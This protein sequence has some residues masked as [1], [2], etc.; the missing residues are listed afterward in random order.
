MSEWKKAAAKLVNITPA[1]KEL[2]VKLYTAYNRKKY[3]KYWKT[4]ELDP[5]MVVF[6]SFLG[7]QYACSPKAMY[8]AMVREE[9]YR[10]Y[11]KIWMFEYPA[12]HQDVIKDENTILVKYRSKEFYEYYARAKYWITNYHLPSGVIKRPGQVYVQTWHGT[13]LK[14]IGCDVPCRSSVEEG[15]G[16]GIEM[17]GSRS[18]E[19]NRSSSLEAAK[20]RAYKEYETEGALIDFV[21]SP[22]PFYTEKFKSAFR[23]GSQAK[24]LEMGYPR[25]DAL[26]T[27]GNEKQEEMKKALGIPRDRKVILYAPTWRDNQHT[28]GTGY[29]YRLGI[30]F[31]KLQ[32]NLEGE[33]MILFRAHYLISSSFDFGK[34]QG[35]IRN[36][37]DYDDI[38]DLYM[39]ADM[40]ITDYSSVF[41]DYACLKRP[42]L[43][44]MYDYAEY[45]NQ[46][47]DFYFDISELPGPVIKEQRD[48]S[49]DIR[50]LFECFEYDEKYE[51]FNEKFN[52]INVPCSRQI[53]REIFG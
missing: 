27:V 45:K 41:F 44:Y 6:E 31:D 37:S 38:N 39:A 49:E 51:R 36:V 29:T 16:G 34:Y 46:I 50:S 43:F 18:V 42:M 8:E 13:P 25:N 14:K 12:K 17:D 47:R 24:V 32:K 5:H 52:P 35:F 48:I 22:S 7:R 10:D 15:R 21:P 23:L 4:C 40:L 19:K 2:A 28:A 26:F 3:K 1:G 30:D 20:R 9:A 11:K 33:A 53:L